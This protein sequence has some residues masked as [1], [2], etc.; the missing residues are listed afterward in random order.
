MLISIVYDSGFGHTTRVAE[1]V[2]SGAGQVDDV[3]V[4]LI[5]VA[6]EMIDWIALEASDAIVLDRLLTTE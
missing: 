1:A 3:D 5:A 2:A 4:R 6:D